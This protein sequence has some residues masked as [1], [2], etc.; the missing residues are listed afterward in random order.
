M[1]QEKKYI[2]EDDKESLC[3]SDG[4]EFVYGGIDAIRQ[5][6]IDVLN[7]VEDKNVLTEMVSYLKSRYHGMK[8]Q[9]ESTITW[10]EYKELFSAA[11]TVDNLLAFEEQLASGNVEGIDFEDFTSQYKQK[12]PWLTV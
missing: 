3:I 4:S 12:Y 1:S 10:E 9:K 8:I 6:G 2:L 11:R 7:G 5:L